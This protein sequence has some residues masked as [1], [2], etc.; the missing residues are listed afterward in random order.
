MVRFE[1]SMSPLTQAYIGYRSSKFFMKNAAPEGVV[2]N[3]GH[4]G[5]R[6]SF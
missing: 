1:F 6:L 4:I 2:D 3:G 5:V